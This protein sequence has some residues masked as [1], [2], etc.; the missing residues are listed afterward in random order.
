MIIPSN[1]ESYS[2]HNSRKIC[3][4]YDVL[5]ALV[6]TYMRWCNGGRRGQLWFL[7]N[8]APQLKPEPHSVLSSYIV[9]ILCI[10]KQV[11]YQNHQP[12]IWSFEVW[13]QF[14]LIHRTWSC[15]R[16]IFILLLYFC[17]WLI[18]GSKFFFLFA[19]NYPK[20]LIFFFSL[21]NRVARHC[22]RYDFL[23]PKAFK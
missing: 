8:V 17:L 15:F 2:S 1:C 9:R 18:C 16:L 6:C 23:T 14:S 10:F 3:N 5:R 19:E 11:V 21:C 7:E 22:H 4:I 12:C 20:E 13:R